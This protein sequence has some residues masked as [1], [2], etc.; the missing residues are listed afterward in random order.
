MQNSI[1]RVQLNPRHERIFEILNKDRVVEFA[2]LSDALGVFAITIRSD[3]V[4][5]MRR[6]RAFVFEKDA[7]VSIAVADSDCCALYPAR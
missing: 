1:A 5:A 4:A 7:E 3:Q 6:E 2:R